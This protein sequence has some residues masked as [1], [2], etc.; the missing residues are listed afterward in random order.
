MFGIKTTVEKEILEHISIMETPKKAW[1]T[2]ASL[3]SKKN[4]ARLQ[5]LENELLLIAQR[6]MTINHFTKN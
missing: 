1:D 2:F 4:D 3:F 5:V 6:E